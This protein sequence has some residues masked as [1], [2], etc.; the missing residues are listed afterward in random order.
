MNGLL[1][2]LRKDYD[3]W[4]KKDREATAVVEKMDCDIEINKRKQKK[5]VPIDKCQMYRH[6]MEQ[7]D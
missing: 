5:W 1:D 7:T 3:V 2:K 6:F 4:N